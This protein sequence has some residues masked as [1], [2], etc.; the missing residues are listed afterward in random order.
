MPKIVKSQALMSCI[1]MF[2]NLLDNQLP[3]SYVLAYYR[4]FLA[5]RNITTLA[6]RNCKVN[7]I[8]LIYTS[9]K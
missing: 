5:A 7:L 3:S 8:L 1:L 6:N 9:L 4:H 2:I